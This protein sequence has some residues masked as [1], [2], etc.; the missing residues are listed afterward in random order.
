MRWC[1]LVWMGCGAPEEPTENDGPRNT[2]PTLPIPDLSG[3]DL[4]ASFQEAMSR[5]LDVHARRAWD[6]HRSSLAESD[7]ACP[8]VY[9]GPLDELNIDEGTTWSDL[10]ETADGQSYEGHLNW[11]TWMA[12]NG[13]AATAIGR[14]TDASRSLTG[15][16][17]VREPFVY[18]RFGLDGSVEDS[19]SLLEAKGG[20]TSWTWTSQVDATLMG[21]AVFDEAD[22]FPEGWR[23]DLYMAAHGGDYESL[24]LRGNLYLYQQRIQ[25]HFDSID[26]D[27]A[28]IEPSATSPDDCALEPKGRFSLRDSE[29]VWYDLIFMPRYAEEVGGD[30]YPNDPLSVCDGCGTLYV[31]GVEQGTVCPDFGVWFGGAIEPPGVDEFVLL[32]Q[33]LH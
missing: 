29:A 23:A 13:D 24:E 28:M 12:A 25:G 20:F 2:T 4:D 32:L 16:A 17:L 8:D 33:D 31:R 7:G 18:T 9:L 3:V 1:L 19:L 21:T 22:P 27:I 5:V 11:T 14:S 15:D 10:C 30:A 6:G 26:V